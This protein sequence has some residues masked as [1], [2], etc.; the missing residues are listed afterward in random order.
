MIEKTDFKSEGIYIIN[1]VTRNNTLN[2][3]VIVTK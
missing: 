3:K 2:K 1:V